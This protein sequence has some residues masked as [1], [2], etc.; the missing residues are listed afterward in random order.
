MTSTAP[1]HERS[2][3]DPR[4]AE[5]PVTSAFASH[6]ELDPEIDFLNHGSF[7]ACPTVV[8][9]AQEEH[10]REMESNPVRFIARTLEPKLDRVRE[11][12]G[13]FLTCDPDDL[14]LVRNATNGVN[15]VLRSLRFEPGDEILTTDQCYNACRNALDFVAGRAG[16]RVVVAPLPF[17][18]QDAR[19][20]VEPILAAATE[21]TR[22]ALIDHITSPTGIVLPMGEILDGL[23]ARGIDV[24]VDGAHAP[25]MLDLDLRALAARGAT[26]Y[27][28]NCHKWL[29]APKG[30]A[31]LFVRRDR[32][33]GLRPLSI[34]HGANSRRTDRGRFRLEHDF[35]GTDDPTPWLCIPT[36]L[37]FLRGLLPGGFAELRRRNRTETLEARARIEGVLGLPPTTPS[38]VIGSLASV[39]L[40]APADEA[41]V[42]AALAHG[43][44][45]LQLQLYEEHGIEVPIMHW[46]RPGRRLLRIAVQVYNRPEQY[47]RLA[48]L[49]PKLLTNA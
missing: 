41:R 19:E 14:A 6:W 24:L 7:G 22:L 26:Y 2:E 11:A 30:S 37:D 43:P 29:C 8:R 38:S 39:P 33:Q 18:L 3:P 20:L 45:P 44:D 16:A 31:F 12:L 5:S 4:H 32:Q 21:R 49:L 17:P 35:Q 42:A 25:G 9:V 13:A 40:P 10:R 27:T 48:S 23:S 1:C 34:G 46:P 28:G 15:T 47:E 36:A